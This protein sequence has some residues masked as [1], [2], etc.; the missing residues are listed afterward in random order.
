MALSVSR[1]AARDVEPGM[2]GLWFGVLV[3]RWASYAWMT[4]LAILTREDLRAPGVAFGSI[5]IIGVWSLWFSVTRGWQRPL[6]LWID[7]TL[8]AALLLVSG[9]V[10]QEGTAGEGA[11]FFATSCPAPAALSVGA[12]VGIGGGIGAGVLLSV[13]LVI[14]RPLNGLPLADLTS[15]QWASLVNGAV[16]YLTAGGAAGA[17]SPVLAKS[18]PPPPPPIHD[19]S[20]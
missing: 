2:Q 4:A 15:D 5:V 9:L 8:A 13:A 19:P 16:Y 14:S 12:A 20:P 10:M 11:P 17:V 7:L 18:P 3:F 1:R 6:A